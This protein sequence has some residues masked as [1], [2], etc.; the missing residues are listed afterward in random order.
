M[1]ALTAANVATSTAATSKR[2]L[3]MNRVDNY[4][5]ARPTITPIITTLIP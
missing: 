5:V 1:I 3:V 4:A 2:R